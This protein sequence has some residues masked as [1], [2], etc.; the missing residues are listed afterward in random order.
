MCH[1]VGPQERWTRSAFERHDRQDRQ[2]KK[3]VLSALAL[4]M[5]TGAF[6]GEITIKDG[7]VRSSNP[8]VAAA[9]MG[10]SNTGAADDRL[11]GASSE[12]AKRVELHTHKMVDD[13]MRMVEVE[14]GFAVPAGGM[15][16]LERGGNHVMLMGLVEPLKQGDEVE[17]TLTFEKA[18]EVTLTLTVDNER[19][20]KGH[21]GHGDHGGHGN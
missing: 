19:K 13:V 17:V 1:G 10:L 5:A 7:Y 14:E 3:T 2:M 18:G 9:F 16:M 12:A 6:A 8:K 15:A 20:A 21:S 11:I 4:L